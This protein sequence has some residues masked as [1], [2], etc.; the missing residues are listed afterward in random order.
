MIFV[1]MKS[2]SVPNEFRY[3]LRVRYSECDAQEIVFNVRYAEYM[4]IAMT[5]YM[6]VIWDGGFKTLAT[7]G[8]D[9]HVVSLHLDWKASARFDDVLC[10]VPKI[11]KLGNSS[12]NTTMKIYNEITSELLVE[13][14]VVNVM[15]DIRTHQP[16]RISDKYREKMQR[17]ISMVVNHAGEIN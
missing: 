6:R 14:Y 15:M 17:N 11:K 10:V 5:E 1:V 16:A 9:A 12:F 8:Y 13:G 3:L 4:D 2:Q 7:D